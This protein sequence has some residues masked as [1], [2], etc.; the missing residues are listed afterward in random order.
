MEKEIPNAFTKELVKIGYIEEDDLFIGDFNA[1]FNEMAATYGF[2]VLRSCL[3]YF[4]NRIKNHG[5]K[6]EF[7]NKINSR[8]GYCRI[9]IEQGARRLTEEPKENPIAKS[10]GLF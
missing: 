2:E 8:L 1:F 4:V 10:W 6:D 9:A 3:W 5:A 7:G